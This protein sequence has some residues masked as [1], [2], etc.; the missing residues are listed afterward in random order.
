MFISI[1]VPTKDEEI[2]IGNLLDSVQMQEYNKGLFDVTVVD[3]GSDGTLEV[4]EKFQ[5]SMEIKIFRTKCGVGTARNIGAGAAKG[6]VILFADADVE[7]PYNI[8]KE[9]AK[10]FSKD[11]ELISLAFP[12]LPSREN[13]IANVFRKPQNLFCKYSI[14]H[15]KSP[16]IAGTCCAY[17]KSLFE[18]LHFLDCAGEDVLFSIQAGNFGKSKYMRDLIVYEDPRRFERH[19][20]VRT[21]IHYVPGTTRGLSNFAKARF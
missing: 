10:E 9:T 3:S 2:H 4:V 15:T 11:K 5:D 8:L 20:F 21:F 7:L 12:I 18:Q 19:G 6:D 17:R 14:K 1:V 16:Y 13:S